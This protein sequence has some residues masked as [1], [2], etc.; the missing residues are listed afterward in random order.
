MVGLLLR[1]VELPFEGYG[2]VLLG[3]PGPVLAYRI[4][5]QEVR[6]ILDVPVHRR[7]R[8]ERAAYLWE[9]YAAVLPSALRPGFR[10][11]LLTGTF[12]GA[13]NEIRARSSYGRDH[14]FLAGDPSAI[15]TH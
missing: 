5:P 6:L 10:A 14:V 9:G 12:E 4:T 1:D 2:H 13:A 11:A 7:G 15:T 3:G 8:Q